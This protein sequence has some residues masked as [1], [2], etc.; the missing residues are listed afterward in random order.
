MTESPTRTEMAFPI[1]CE[2]RMDKANFI[3]FLTRTI[4][5]AIT[6]TMFKVGNTSERNMSSFA[7]ASYHTRIA[8]PPLI[9]MH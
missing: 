3:A 2:G 8:I 9:H 6:S 5:S 4:K 7:Q 1:R